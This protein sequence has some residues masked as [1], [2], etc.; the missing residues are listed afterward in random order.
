M[1]MLLLQACFLEAAAA[2]LIIPPHTPDVWGG[3]AYGAALGHSSHLFAFSGADGPTQEGSGF[4]GLLRPQRYSVQFNQLTLDLQLEDS[5]GNGTLLAASSDVVAV[6]ASPGGQPELVL[7]YSAWNVLLG[8]S[9]KVS[10]YKTTA[11]ASAAPTSWCNLTGSWNYAPRS[12]DYRFEEAADGSF[13]VTS[14]AG[15]WQQATGH[16]SSDGSITITFK[17]ANGGTFTDHA[18]A[19]VAPACDTIQWRVHSGEWRKHS[20]PTPSPVPPSPPGCEL[21]DP[22]M[23]ICH[24]SSDKSVFAVAFGPGGAAAKAASVAANGL[25]RA[26]VDAVATARLAPLAKLP[27]PALNTSTQ[28]DFEK[29]NQKVFSVM[30][31]NTLA[32]E[33]ICHTHWSTPDKVP[34]QAMWLWDSC[35]HAIGRQVVEPELAW[36]F[37]H[38]MLISAAPDGH[39]PIQAE[40]WNGQVSGD[41][42]PPLL[43]LATKFV[44]NAGGVN[45]S[46]LAWALP[47]LERYI[48][49]DFSNRDVDNDHLLNWHRG[50]ESGLDN[51]PLWD[52]P[53]SDPLHMGATE[54]SS[55][56]ALEMLYISE[57]HRILGN[58]TG[59]EHWRR[60][61]NLTIEAIHSR[62]WDEE[63][64]FYYYVATGHNR[65]S[66]DSAS[67]RSDGAGEFVKVQTPCGF[68]PLLLPGVS[69]A[70]VA[71]LIKHINDPSKF[72]SAS[73]L[74]TVAM[75]YNTASCPASSTNMWRRP[76][77]TNTNLFTIWGLRNYGHVPG[78]LETAQ[79]LQRQTVEMVA[80][81][82]ERWGTTFEFYDSN[83]KVEPPFLERK[84]SQ[85][86][87][88]VR[89]YHWTAA[90]TFLLLHRPNTSLP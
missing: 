30:R 77:W 71:A 31:V 62:M 67:S 20:P 75:D 50:T 3:A 56:A 8:Y 69:D 46:Q 28:L 21:P 76:A 42:Q 45:E 79:K 57:F 63:D 15:S 10:L 9:P 43:A 19:V 88:G 36:E 81:A 52:P 13:V 5:A 49:W 35:F 2:A 37:L 40:P 48:E 12:Y 22:S 17:L 38:A 23:A 47:R 39:V 73:P 85:S 32:P 59:E 4:T 16:V 87:G 64:Q 68:A 7:A 25:T 82:Y 80:K 66:H 33:G 74:P 70:R 84:S 29:L 11:E 44:Y 54:F 51:S 14:A 24:S 60:Q 53:H 83:D 78:A 34:H 61:A 6:A 89:D 41:T 55:Y 26:G 27:V 65:S 1:N 72:A 58:Q 18:P 86:S 90:N